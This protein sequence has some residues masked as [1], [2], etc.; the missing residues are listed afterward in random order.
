[1]NRPC[2]GL[3]RS[4]FSASRRFTIADVA[5]MLAAAATAVVTGYCLKTARQSERNDR[6]CGKAMCK[7][8]VNL[9]DDSDM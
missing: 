6:V 8:R 1:M 5:K 9:H 4:A 2:G 3:S 7:I